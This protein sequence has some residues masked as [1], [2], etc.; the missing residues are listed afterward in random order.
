MKKTSKK[1]QR[2]AQKRNAIFAA[3]VA[4]GVA[5]EV[6]ERDSTAL[7]EFRKVLESRLTHEI[8]GLESRRRNYQ[9]A[10]GRCALK[11]LLTRGQTENQVPPAELEKDSLVFEGRRD[12]LCHVLG[13]FGKLFVDYTGRPFF[14]THN[15]NTANTAAP[16]P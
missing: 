10:A 8:H 7:V 9:T 5:R 6:A 15:Q 12:E 11:A 13:V 14:D 1:S 4:R 16:S 3:A 2:L